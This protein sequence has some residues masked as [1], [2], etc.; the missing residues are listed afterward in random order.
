MQNETYTLNNKYIYLQCKFRHVYM[1]FRQNFSQKKY[2]AM[3]EKTLAETVHYIPKG[4]RKRNPFHG[5]FAPLSYIYIYFFEMQENT[6]IY[7]FTYIF[8]HIWSRRARCWSHIEHVRCSH[9]FPHVPPALVLT[10]WDLETVVPKAGTNACNDG[11][12]I[13]S[14]RIQFLKLTSTRSCLLSSTR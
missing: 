4:L 3:S 10:R 8:I 2:F 7:N 6:Y 13:S 14:K 5:P 12:T 1:N 11:M 9:T